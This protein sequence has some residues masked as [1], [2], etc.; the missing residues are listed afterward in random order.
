M[1]KRLVDLISA[2]NLPESQIDKNE[3][4]VGSKRGSPYYMA[5][6]LFSDGGVY[7]FQSDLWALG[8]VAY[9]LATGISKWENYIFTRPSYVQASLHS[10]AAASRNS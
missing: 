10:S 2:T 8:C 1:A 6:E 7:S 3:M 5:P 4:L 9:E